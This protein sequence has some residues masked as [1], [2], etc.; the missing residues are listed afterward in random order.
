MSVSFLFYLFAVS[1]AGSIILTGILRTMLRKWDI[2][3]HPNERSSHSIP[4]PR[5]GGLAVM[6]VVLGVWTSASYVLAGV[7]QLDCNVA[8]AVLALTVIFWFEDVKGLSLIFRLAAQL[9]VTLFLLLQ[10]GAGGEVGEFLIF[11]G[12]LPPI[13]DLVMAWLLWVCFINLFNFMDGIDG[14]S[15]AESVIIGIGAVAIGTMV[16]SLEV[17]IVPGVAVVGAMAGFFFW[18]SPP[19]R[20]FLGDVGSVPLGFL[21]GWILLYMAGHGLW[22]PALI[23]PLYYLADAGITLGRRVLR[24]EKFWNAHRDHFYQ[25]AVKRGLSHATVSAMVFALGI[26]LVGLAVL[27]MTMPWL[28]LS[29][30]I[31]LVLVF[32]VFLKGRGRGW[33]I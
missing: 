5:G 9:A 2:F 15:T 8:L 12:L 24:G 32:L 13:V 21:L 11:Q 25:A 33:Y 4:T 26:L 16:Q 23:L 28:S 3:D 20:I 1:S 6:V 27:S 22:V 19:A 7:P 14:I 18:N 10:M 31:G 30:A 17:I 29:V